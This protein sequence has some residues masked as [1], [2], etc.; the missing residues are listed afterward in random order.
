MY[1][2]QILRALG[3]YYYYFL[4]I[5]FSDFDVNQSLAGQT[6][7]SLSLRIITLLSLRHPAA[8]QFCRST[9]TIT[10]STIKQ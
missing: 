8:R 9:Y 6:L 1:V 3:K 5:E 7:T 2:F 4:Y 10:D